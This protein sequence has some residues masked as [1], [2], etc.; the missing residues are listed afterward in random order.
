MNFSYYRTYNP[1]FWLGRPGLYTN[2]R[3]NF[4]DVII[5]FNHLRYATVSDTDGLHMSLSQE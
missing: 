3:N 2:H 1:I 4:S 5:I